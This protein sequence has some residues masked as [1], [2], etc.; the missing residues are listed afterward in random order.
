[1]RKVS[2]KAVRAAVINYYSPLGMLSLAGTLFDLATALRF[3]PVA[4]EPGEALL[5][6]SDK[7]QLDKLVNML[8]ERPHVHLIVC[9]VSTQADRFA[10]FGEDTGTE[11]DN[12][13]TNTSATTS[14]L[15]EP[16]LARLDALARER[17]NVVKA[18]LVEEKQINPQRLIVCTPKHQLGDRQAPRTELQL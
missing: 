17:S 16:Q 5:D 8:A 3:E 15:S 10:W 13:D 12:D 6:N 18:Y 7:Q 11:P 2:A 14:R 1:M 4:F 9:G